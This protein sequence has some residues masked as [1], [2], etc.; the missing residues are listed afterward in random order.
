VIAFAWAERSRDVLQAGGWPVEWHAYPMDHAAVIDELIAA[1][2]FITGSL[3][4]SART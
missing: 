2:T 3:T 1:G 4:S